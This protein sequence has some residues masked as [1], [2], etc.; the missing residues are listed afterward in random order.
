MNTQTPQ[1]F[2]TAAEVR[3]ALNISRSTLWK[4]VAEQGFPRQKIGGVIRY[5]TDKV[6]AW[7]QKHTLGDLNLPSGTSSIA[8][9]IATSPASE[10]IQ[11]KP[12]AIIQD[13]RTVKTMLEEQTALLR[14]IRDLLKA[15]R[16]LTMTLAGQ[17]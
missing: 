12:T 14:E 17:P 16:T 15:K 13:E 8:A 5:P 4:W 10:A 1:R 7:L 9:A 11:Q 2:L 6:E 3:T